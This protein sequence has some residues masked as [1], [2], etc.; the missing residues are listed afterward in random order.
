MGSQTTC[1]INS[2]V[3]LGAGV[4]FLGVE[5]GTSILGITSD[6]FSKEIKLFRDLTFGSAS[7][8][9]EKI[10]TRKKP[11]IQFPNGSF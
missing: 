10:I 9:P 2:I 1:K 3:S 5:S 4:A 6:G 7:L 11:L 8:E